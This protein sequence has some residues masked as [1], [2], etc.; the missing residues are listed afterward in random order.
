MN[1]QT[2]LTKLV[3]VIALLVVA[4][5]A[6][7]WGQDPAQ[8]QNPE[9]ILHRLKRQDKNNDGKIDKDEAVGMLR[10]VFDRVD[11]NGDGLID[12]AE[13]EK[14]VE[15]I[16]RQQRRDNRPLRQQR[17]V[18]VPDSVEFLTDVA[19]REGNA[20]WRL[21][22]ALPKAESE[23][24]RPGLVMVHGGGWR[25]GDKRGGLLSVLPI[26]YAE[27]GYVC[28]SV[29]YRLT[30]EAPFP[31]CV[32]DVKCAVRWLRANAEKYNVD[33]E[34]IGGFGSSAGAHLV[35]M[36]GLVGP[37]TGLE[38]DGPYQEQSSLLQAVC[39][40]ATP[41]DFT[42]W[43]GLRG[44]GSF[45]A[46]P[47]DTLDERASKASPV[48]YAHES[49]PP[50]LVIHGTVDQIVPVS[51]GDRFV[52]ALKKAGAKDVTYL[53]YENAGHVVFHQRADETEPAM[54]EFF[55]RTLGTKHP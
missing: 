39:C 5:T 6:P 44:D 41:A 17:S 31:A 48:T 42:N 24:P 33:P 50:F 53:R 40:S 13:L 26:Q 12:E 8:R 35:A 15:W 46:G 32:E 38:G 10:Q 21:D 4:L 49:A 55:A 19:Y 43:G 28:I 11:A 22:L 7:S 1:Q 37:E 16:R 45:L 2:Y 34:R 3:W 29:N 36:L 52:E 23:S 30:G 14:L 9:D 25:S 20:A 18:T 47:D 54:E 27:R 51:Q